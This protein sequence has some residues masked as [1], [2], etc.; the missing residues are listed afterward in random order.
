MT[1]DYC[2][3]KAECTV[4]SSNVCQ[5]L[6]RVYTQRQEDPVRTCSGA[7]LSPRGWQTTEEGGCCLLWSRPLF[8]G[9]DLLAFTQKA[10]YAARH[11]QGMCDKTSAWPISGER[12]SG[13]CSYIQVYMHH[14]M[15]DSARS[16]M[17]FSGRPEKAI[18]CTRLLQWQTKT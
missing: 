14:I 17:Q 12:V 6:I 3:L 11:C 8:S 2:N 10:M 4:K 16:R 7:M 15:D 9:N 18:Y 1:A 13:C 5:T